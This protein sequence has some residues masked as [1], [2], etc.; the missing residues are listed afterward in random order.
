MKSKNRPMILFSGGLDSTALLI[1]AL[2]NN[3]NPI[4]LHIEYN[5]P[6]ADQELKAVQK[7]S[8]QYNDFCTLHMHKIII[9]AE[10]MKIGAGQKG[11][12]F[13][14]GRNLLFVAIAHNLASLYE[15]DQIWIGCTKNDY[16]HYEDCRPEFIYNLNQILK[17]VVLV[18]PFID[19]NRDQIRDQYKSIDFSNTWSCY[20]PIEN[21]S[22]CGSCDSCLQD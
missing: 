3:L 5:H 7:I 15:C 16:D 19:Q 14:P 2:E 12:R 20:E 21:D 13:V 6:A 10:A 1:H 17:T 8:D 4:L 11:S 9:N 22:P 18:A